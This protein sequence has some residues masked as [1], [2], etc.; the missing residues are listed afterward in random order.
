MPLQEGSSQETISANIAT[1]VR[2]GYEQD[3]AVAIAYSKAGKSRGDSR[4]GIITSGLVHAAAELPGKLTEG[5]N[6]I[7]ENIKGASE[8]VERNRPDKVTGDNKSL[9][10]PTLAPKKWRPA[11]MGGDNTKDVSVPMI[12]SITDT[13]ED[14][15]DAFLVYEKN[16]HKKI[17]DA[18]DPDKADVGDVQGMYSKGTR[19]R[20]AISS[21]T[22]KKP[23]FLKTHDEGTTL[24]T[25]NKDNRA[26]WGNGRTRPRG[27]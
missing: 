25:M 17:G 13:G 2:E 14:T 22:G 12:E 15:E 3:Q 10:T 11:I 9:I 18:D 21:G 23:S 20:S 6:R 16:K 8:Q 1:L 27:R 24:R 7:T 4:D 19:R 26:F 5:M